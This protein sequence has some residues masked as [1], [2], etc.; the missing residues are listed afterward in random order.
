MSDIH[1]STDAGASAPRPSV[2]PA[3]P[4]GFT[5]GVTPGPRVGPA[6]GAL[7]ILDGL[8]PMTVPGD[9]APE[10]LQ[11]PELPP[12]PKN[13]DGTIGIDD[14]LRYCVDVKASDLHVK[15]GA[16]PTI[17]ISGLLQPLDHVVLGAE[18][19][20]ALSGAMMGAKEREELD[21]KGEVDFA[22]S[23]PGLGRFRVNIHRQRGTLG[24]AARRILP[25]A[26][27]FA[28]LEL[29]GIV[30]KLANEHRGLLLVTGPTSSGKTTTCGAIIK[31]INQTR[32]CHIVT[33]EDPIEILHRDEL[34][35]VT[36]REVGQDTTTFQLAL[37]AA[38]RQDP[39]VIFVG[40]IR[41]TETVQAALQ[42]AETGHF[43]IATIHTTD[44]VETINRIVD[45][46]PS[47]QQKQVRVALA[48]SLVGVMTQ[49]L[50][51]RVGGGR[52]PA[53]EVLVSNG[54][55]QDCII[56]PEKTHE[57]HDIVED[58][59]FY[60]MQTFDQALIKLY[61]EG[62]VT[63]DDAKSAANSAHDF[64][65]SLQKAGILKI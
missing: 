18:E 5:P 45:F 41:D 24:I 17:R 42:A 47:H 30:E 63:L 19:C 10:M 64:Q 53:I 1:R 61:Q 35:I 40:E 46:F 65:L 16:P 23:V 7:D 11:E 43:V 6:S 48:G 49:R 31:H 25:N 57:I 59:G 54:R 51:P 58:S 4:G 32:R 21:R 55:I 13:T 3:P 29:P 26:P 56:D 22:Y 34:A 50:L 12:L 15:A 28:D 44:V 8:E 62:V 38:M 9:P 14:L 33:I 60:G 37:R 52:A 2:P 27:N 39:D 36:Q 20:N